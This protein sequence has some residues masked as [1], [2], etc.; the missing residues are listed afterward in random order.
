MRLPLSA[1]IVAGATIAAQTIM[2]PPVASAGIPLYE[3]AK[4]DFANELAY[5]P[6]FRQAWLNSPAPAPSVIDNP[7]CPR[8]EE[9][10]GRISC[11]AEFEYRGLWRLVEGTV[12]EA[13]NA[14]NT[15]E[16]GSTT[17]VS[18]GNPNDT[19]TIYFSRKWRRRWRG[20]PGSCPRGW[21]IPGTIRTNDGA[22]HADM[23]SDAYYALRTHHTPLR[24]GV[25][26]TDLGGFD[27]IVIYRCHRS[28]AATECANAVG[29]AFSYTP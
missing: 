25:H 5:L 7:I 1:L 2:A 26:G 11:Q 19:A 29:D 13:Q 27:P 4:A 21:G 20:E 9:F 6:Q 28:G 12:T 15:F 10:E 3:I 14:N 24:V 8:V 17:P 23:A 18:G 16:E 22:C